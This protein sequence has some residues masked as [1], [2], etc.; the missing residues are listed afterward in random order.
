M[1]CVMNT[2]RLSCVLVATLWFGG[3]VGPSV[4]LADAERTDAWTLAYGGRLYDDWTKEL[5]RW[6]MKDAS[7]HPAYPAK[8]KQKG[9]ATWR[10]KECHGWDYQG[11]DGSYSKGSHFTGIKGLREAVGMPVEQIA[12]VIRDKNH[13]YSESMLPNDAVAAL[14]LFVSKGQMDVDQVIDRA[15]RT[16]KGDPKRGAR[17]FQTI[18]ATCHG[19]DG[20]QINFKTRAE[21]EFIGTIASDNPWEILH[22]I[23]SGQPGAPMP[24][25]GVLDVQDLLDVLTYAQT[26]PRK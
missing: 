11:K 2:R 16:A 21:P 6:Y 15:T 8:G 10:C 4:A 13:G 17:F 7:T 19:F 20:R 24:S 9:S 14:S 23:R 25:L 12:R 22:K 5:Y 3:V 18:C 1:V 26:L